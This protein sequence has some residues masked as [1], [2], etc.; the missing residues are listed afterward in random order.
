MRGVLP[1]VHRASVPWLLPQEAVS[2]ARVLEVL[3]AVEKQE[4][5]SVLIPVAEVVA[6]VQSV[7]E[8]ALARVEV[9]AMEHQTR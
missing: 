4:V 1:E 8:G 7:Q 5:L 3:R 9:E 2:E 6:I